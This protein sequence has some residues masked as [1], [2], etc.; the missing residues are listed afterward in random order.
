MAVVEGK[1]YAFGGYDGSSR[2]C[3]VECYD[4]QVHSSTPVHSRMA[5]AAF[6]VLSGCMYE[7]WK[8]LINSFPP[9]DIVGV[10]MVMVSP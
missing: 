2:L 1:L 3:T 7:R 5:A 8:R 6:S 10:F 4:P 9:N